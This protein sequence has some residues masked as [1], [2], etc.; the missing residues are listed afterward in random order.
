MLLSDGPASSRHT[1]WS[2]MLDKANKEKERV[3]KIN[4][5]SSVLEFGHIIVDPKDWPIC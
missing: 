3:L 5:N 2:L 1:E 4:E